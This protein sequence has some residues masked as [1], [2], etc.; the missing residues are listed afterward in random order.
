MTR[1]FSPWAAAIS[2]DRSKVNEPLTQAGK[3]V[4]RTNFLAEESKTPRG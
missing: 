4:S 1:A 2:P 3:P